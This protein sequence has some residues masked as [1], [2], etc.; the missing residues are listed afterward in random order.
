[1]SPRTPS[2]RWPARLAALAVA[3]AVPLAFTA[4]PALADDAALPI[5]DGTLDWGIK[6][7][8]RSY[9]TGPIGNGRIDTTDGALA[10]DTGFRF[11][12]G[13]GEYD[14]GSHDISTAFA[15]TVRFLAH[16]DGDDWALDL[17]VTDLRVTTD[18]ADGTGSIIADVTSKDLATGAPVDYDDVTL[19]E[20]DL[21]DVTPQP[22]DD[23]TTLADIP[24]SL[25]AEGAEAFAGFYGA[26]TELDPATVT[27]ATGDGAGPSDDANVVDGTL[28]WGV[29]ESFRNY[30]VGPIANGRVE[31]SDGATDTG[32]GYRFPAATGTFDD[33]AD[34][35]SVDFTG[36]VRFLGHQSGDDY[37]LDLTFTDL[38]VSVADGSGTLTSGNLV[39]AELA[40]P[41]GIDAHDG[42]VNLEGLS[43]TLTAEGAEAFA[44]FYAAGDELDPVTVRIALTDDA[45]LPGGG[46]DTG[47]QDSAGPSF[48]GGLPV[49]GSPIGTVVGIGAALLLAAGGL[50]WWTRRHRVTGPTA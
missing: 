24:A 22:G 31:L 14:T 5:T 27:V 23:G 39:I 46:N 50:A 2:R 25:T 33:D 1:M 35:L 18:L 20:L 13:T 8:F 26:G 34:T 11:G 38:S 47:D 28:D 3:G 21:S 32:D 30:V 17:T 43:A 16:P 15:G 10:T 19:A 9:V 4:V 45:R 48:H 41:A 29:K 6:E 44:G 7:S 49:T 40:V 37:E 36:A 12:D 42:V